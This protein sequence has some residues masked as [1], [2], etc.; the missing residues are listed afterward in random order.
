MG[1]RKETEKNRLSLFQKSRLWTPPEI[2]LVKNPVFFLLRLG[3]L[4]RFGNS[5]KG[6]S[7]TI[8]SPSKGEVAFSY[9]QLLITSTQVSEIISCTG[10]LFYLNLSYKK[11]NNLHNERK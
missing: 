7:S 10:F 5:I 2:S 9:N 1:K 8:T 11:G 3:K 4:F 6:R